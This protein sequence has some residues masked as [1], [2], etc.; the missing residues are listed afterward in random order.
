MTVD[1]DLVSRHW[2]LPIDLQIS[3]YQYVMLSNS[4]PRKGTWKFFKAHI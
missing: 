1:C 2:D 3:V 4:P